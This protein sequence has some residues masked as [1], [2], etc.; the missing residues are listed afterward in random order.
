MAAFLIKDV[1]IFT[2]EDEIPNGFVY[3]QS[4]LIRSFG[5]TVPDKLDSGILVIS[6]PNH[7]LLPGLIDCHIHA[8]KGNEQALY[9]SIKF[10]VTTVMDMHNEAVNVNKLKILA[11][12]DKDC[13]DFKSAGMAATIDNGWPIPVVTAHDKSEETMAEIATWPKL[14]TKAD[15]DAYMKTNVMETGADY[16]KLMHESGKAMGWEFTEPT[17]EL[18]AMVVAAAHSYGRVAVAHATAMKDHLTVLRAGVDGLAHTF[19]DQP[20]TQELIDAYKVNNA[21]LNPTLTAMGS[22]TT[23]GKEVQERLAHDP[24]VQK[25]LGEEE[26]ARLCQCMDFHAEGSKL[27]YAYESVRQ[28]KN[29]GI[30]ILCGSDAATPA[31]GTAWGASLHQEL[32]IFV[33][34]CGFTP[35][36]ALRAATSLTAKRFGF[37]DRGMIAE[38]KRADLLL[39]EGNPLED[40]DNTL[41]IRGVWRDGRMCSEYA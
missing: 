1:R 19:F 5:S 17:Q 9:Q 3:I 22:L 27:E 8:S 21:W 31:R 29:A 24:R 18:Q 39:V 16:I 28:L 2:G 6:K 20:P 13:A 10:G 33:D 35:V 14:K 30:D 41:N 37:R 36:E 34:E 23:E 15:V 38:D 7:T 4:G 25:H 12:A 11:K 32:R 26:T 40:I